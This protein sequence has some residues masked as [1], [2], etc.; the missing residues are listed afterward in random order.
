M[1]DGDKNQ[2]SFLENFKI[3]VETLKIIIGLI[4]V[5]VTWGIRTE[6]PYIEM[7]DKLMDDFSQTD[8]RQDIALIT[9]DETIGNDP[10]ES[11]WGACHFCVGGVS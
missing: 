11:K 9:L 3:G 8:R 6:L 4:L 5:W 2:K 10:K 7:V 1:S